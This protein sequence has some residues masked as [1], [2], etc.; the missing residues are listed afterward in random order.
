MVSG[1]CEVATVGILFG[2]PGAVCSNPR[3]MGLCQTLDKLISVTILA[4][5]PVAQQLCCESRCDA[6]ATTAERN[7][8]D[9]KTSS[10]CP[11]RPVLFADCC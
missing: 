2:I 6:N 10:K 1:R 11:E 4:D 9:A 3:Q 5:N 8:W 7:P